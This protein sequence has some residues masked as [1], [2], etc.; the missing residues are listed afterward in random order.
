MTL[1]RYSEVLGSE[2]LVS[3]ITDMDLQSRGRF[4][5]NERFA[6]DVLPAMLLVSLSWFSCDIFLVCLRRVIQVTL[7]GLVV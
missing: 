6:N 1:G 3:L 4:V 7:P 5:R 2:E